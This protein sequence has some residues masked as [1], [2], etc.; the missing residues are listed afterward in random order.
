M[1][2]SRKVRQTLFLSVFYR[3]RLAVLTEERG[4]NLLHLIHVL[5]GRCIQRL[6]RDR[7][8]RAALPTHTLLQGWIRAQKR[9]ELHKALGTREQGHQDI[10]QFVLWA[11]FDGLLRDLHAST[12]DVEDAAS[13]QMSRQGCQAGMGAKKGVKWCVRLR[14]DDPPLK[15][16]RYRTFS[17]RMDHCSL[18]D[19]LFLASS[20]W[21]QFGQNLGIELHNPGG[22]RLFVRQLDQ[23][24]FS[25]VCSS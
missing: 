5:A 14:H 25:G 4:E 2:C 3:S 18:F 19:K 21:R 1:S 10:D 24:F 6:L 20:F 22:F 17:L 8:F 13:V 16:Y 12:H 11:I 15:R 23:S 7:L 9:I